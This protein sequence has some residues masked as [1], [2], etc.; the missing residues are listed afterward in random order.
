MFLDIYLWPFPFTEKFI[1][2]ILDMFNRAGPDNGD[3]GAG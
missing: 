2:L 1:S 3:G